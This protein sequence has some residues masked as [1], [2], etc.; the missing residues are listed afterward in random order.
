MKKQI[1]NM[2]R[3][4]LILVAALCSQVFYASA[5]ISVGMSGATNANPLFSGG[6]F[7]DTKDNYGF[8]NNY[9]VTSPHGQESGD[10]WYKVKLKTSATVSISLCNSGNMDTY[11][12]VLN[13]TGDEIAYNDDNGPSCPSS[14]MSSLQTTLGAGV[15]YVV[16]EGYSDNTGPITTQISIPQTSLDLDPLINTVSTW[17]PRIAIG[18]ITS[19]KSSE[20]NSSEVNISNKYIDAVGNTV[21]QVEK[22]ASTG[23]R[24]IVQPYEFDELGRQVKQYLPYTFGGTTPGSYRPS[25]TV[26]EQA[27]FYGNTSSSIIASTGAPYAKT[28]IELSPLQRPLEQGA[29]GNYGQ[30]TGSGISGSGHTE[31]YDYTTNNTV[32]I[33][34]LSNTRIAVLYNASVD[35]NGNYTLV[36]SLAGTSSLYYNA[37]EL[38]VQIIKDANWIA[39]DGRV[40]TKE[41]YT[42]SRGQKILTRSFNKNAGGTVEILSTYLVYDDF[43]NLCY[44]LPPGALPDNATNVSG[45]VI[46]QDILDKFCYQY[47]YDAKGRQIALKKPGTDWQYS[48]YNS[49]DQ[50]VAIQDGNDRLRK[51]WF[52]TK[53]DGLG[54]VI[55]KG[56]W[57]N[58][59]AAI[60]RNDLQ[61]L[62]NQQAKLWEEKNVT[63]NGYTTISWP[64]TI[65]RYNLINYYDDYTIPGIPFGYTYQTY[66]GNPAGSSKQTT[67]KLTAT[68]TWLPNGTTELWSVFFYD[69]NG[70]VIQSQLGH[71]LS[72]KD[73]VNSEYLFSGRISKTVRTHSSSN[74]GSLVIANRY[75]YDHHGREINLY[76]K[77]GADAEVLLRQTVYN[78]LGQVIDLRL[79][80]K[81]GTTNFLQ[82]LDFRYNE[83]GSLISIN[84]PDLLV[85]SVSND[86]DSNSGPDLFGLKLSYHDDPVAPQYNGNIAAMRWKTSQVSTVQTVAPPK[87]G[88]QYRYDVLDRL[89]SAISEKNGVV[90]NGHNETVTYDRNG[91]IITLKRNAFTGGGIQEIDNLAY[92]YDGYRSKKIDD[93]STATNKTLGYDDKQKVAEEHLYDLNGNMITDLNKG[94]TIIYNESNLVQQITFGTNHKLEFLYDRTGRKLQSKYTKDVAVYT[95]DYIGGIQ[96]EQGQIAFV[97]TDEGR[98]RKTG[99]SYSYEYDI[100]DHLGNARVTFMADLTN[101]NQP[102]AKVIQQNS[103]YPYGLA[104]YGDAA[105]NLHLSYVSGEKSKYLY[106]G[107]ELYDQGGLNW[108]DHGARMYDPAIG[109]WSVTDPVNQFVNPYLAMGNNPVA[110][111]DPDGKFAFIPIL[112]GALIGGTVNTIAHWDRIQAEGW[113]AGVKAF[114]VGAFAGGLGV[115]TGGAAVAGMSVSSVSTAVI[116][117]SIGAVY[118]DMAL[119]LGNMMAFGDPYDLSPARLGTTALIGGVTGGLLQGISNSAAGRNFWTGK[120]TNLKGWVEPIEPTP[121]GVKDDSGKI[122][123]FD[124]SVTPADPIAGDYITNSKNTPYPKVVVEGYGEVPFPQGPYTPNNS[125]VLR[126]SFTA[127]YKA[128]FKEW[129][130]SQGRPW[131]QV[132]EGSTLNIHHIKPL[133][134]GGTNAFDNLVP[135]VQPEQHQPF[136][137]WW[138]GFKQ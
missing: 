87:M 10:I 17:V 20:N 79:H 88:Y 63:G 38:F 84:D 28:S 97:Q 67:N 55:I 58:N 42:N 104:M 30:L 122:V 99:T 9:S 62:V 72:G 61:T 74:A 85:T 66:V 57:N 96:Y 70:R 5:Q 75:E 133:A 64:Q 128:D 111:I 102:V 54:R 59:N 81:S 86:G 47:R 109:R 106:S 71:H 32:A 26:S 19:L 125:S 80:Q 91:N 112:V 52:V 65:T 22:S 123:P 46:T 136:T 51:E 138:R 3:L 132:P 134:Q 36:H 114:G 6:V 108:Y 127:K 1:S 90:D 82:S 100:T 39:A 92:T 18:T 95:I 45:N 76:S 83:S 98:A 15:Y 113:T 34:D 40:R 43:G 121:Y 49:L 89:T 53:Y 94:T 131:P 105:N 14:R 68:K 37:N 44:T 107:K 103:Y 135:L 77:I 93:L 12:H 50:L 16:V 48:V 27:A 117:G 73:I 2:V 60:S 21:Q 31:K 78:E 137:N 124:D 56:V 41:I 4:L 101:P 119:G 110:R 23:G 130:I 24:D 33:S 8:G 126:T 129:W 13:S 116:G 118:N 120:F 29:P 115:A 25:A 35:G 7:T 11:L 69:E